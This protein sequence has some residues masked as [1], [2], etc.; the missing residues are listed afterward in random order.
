MVTDVNGVTPAWLYC[1]DAQRYSFGPGKL[2]SDEA[3][4]IGK[5]TGRTPEFMM[6]RQGFYPRGGRA[7]APTGYMT[8]SGGSPYPRALG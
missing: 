6:P 7:G 1:D 3:R 5:V 2:S 4:R 8:G